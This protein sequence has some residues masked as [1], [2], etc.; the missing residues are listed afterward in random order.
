MVQE[1]KKGN[2]QVIAM[3]SLPATFIIAGKFFS[4]HALKSSCVGRGSALSEA[5]KTQIIK[6]DKTKFEIKFTKDWVFCD[7]AREFEPKFTASF[8]L[9]TL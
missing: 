6:A 9:P 8:A 1:G 5:A 3:P 2:Y 7:R 4:K